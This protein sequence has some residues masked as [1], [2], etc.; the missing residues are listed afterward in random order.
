MLKQLITLFDNLLPDYLIWGHDIERHLLYLIAVFVSFFLLK[1]VVFLFLRRAY[2]FFVKIQDKEQKAINRFINLSL[3]AIWFFI[4]SRF[5]LIFYVYKAED[6]FLFTAHTVPLLFSYIF[7]Y[8]FL[9]K[10]WKRFWDSACSP[11]MQNNLNEQETRYFKLISPLINGLF[12]IGIILLFMQILGF[13]SIDYFYQLLGLDFLGNSI[14]Q[15]LFFSFLIFITLLLARTIY[16]QMNE[17]ILK[18]LEKK[19]VNSEKFKDYFFK[20][21]ETPLTYLVLLIGFKIATNALDKVDQNGQPEIVYDAL[22]TIVNILMTLDIGWLLW[23]A[24]DKL[25]YSSIIPFFSD[26]QRYFDIQ[27]VY[28]ARK[29]SKTVVFVSTFIVLIKSLGQDPGTILAGMGIGGLAISFAAK[30]TLSPFVS[31]LAIYATRPFTVGDYIRIEGFKYSGLVEEIGFRATT[32][33][34][35]LGSQFSVPNDNIMNS[36][37]EN[38]SSKGKVLDSFRLDLDI[39]N[40]PHKRIQAE[41]FFHSI[42]EKHPN[43]DSP[44]FTFLGYQKEAMRMILHYWIND[45][46]KLYEIRSTIMNEIDNKFRENHIELDTNSV[47]VS[48]GNY[49]EEGGIPPTV[50]NQ[51]RQ[52]KDK[53]T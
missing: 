39:G 49:L 36:T 46:R 48:L 6:P 14:K 38:L 11:F 35:D 27:I 5:S 20:A 37:I 25:F 40:D 22:S 26:R 15:Y 21:L 44:G 13:D 53:N 10:L 24:I 12:K 47:L 1:I 19:G 50:I 18:A 51:L 23:M 42:I 3:I 34:T 7:L 33:R 16:F 29:I 31:G 32:F 4:V 8:L 43:C 52:L 9:S 45:A 28:L 17:L 30:D 2:N 41:D